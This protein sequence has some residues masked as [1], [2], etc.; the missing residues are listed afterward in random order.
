MI[1]RRSSGLPFLS[2]LLSLSAIP[3]FAGLPLTLYRVTYLGTIQDKLVGLILLIT[4]AVILSLS[5]PVLSFSIPLSLIAYFFPVITAGGIAVI[6]LY[7]VDFV[8]KW[9]RSLVLALDSASLSYLLLS[10][11][12]ERYDFL[13]VPSAVFQV[14]EAQLIPFVLF[15]GVVLGL[16]PKGV[17][18]VRRVPWF[19]GI[20]AALAVSL[21]PLIPTVNPKGYAETVDWRFYYG[22]LESPTVHGWFFLTRPLY[23]SLLFALSKVFPA[24]PL[25]LYQFPFLALAYTLSAYFLG[26][27]WRKGYGGLTSLCAAISPMLLTFLYSG[28]QANLFS[29]ALEFSSL[30]LLIRR[31]RLVLAVIL[32][33]LSLLSHVYAWAQLEAGIF[34]YVC[35]AII[36]GRADVYLRRYA[37]L[38]SPVLLIGLSLILGGVFPVPLTYNSMGQTFFQFALLSW[39]S[40]NSFLYYALSVYGNRYMPGEILGIYASSV[41]AMPF[42]GVAQNLVIDLPLFLQLSASTSNLRDDLFKPLLLLLASWAMI[43]SLNSVPF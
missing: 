23:L 27:S 3:L 18:A 39:G 6:S 38:T 21:I 24:L 43:M 32:S 29:I 13:M 10:L 17:G 8:P 25:S 2:L 34:V 37:L 40:A 31:E 30:A 11:L 7:A 22:W 19:S 20:L 33:Y 26:E 5:K 12:G 9:V 35:Y 16:F 15:A 42:T 4:A 28:L 14:G 36:T 41:L 1:S